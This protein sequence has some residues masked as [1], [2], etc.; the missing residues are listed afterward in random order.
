[1]LN[2]GV[3]QGCATPL[4]RSHMEPAQSVLSPRFIN[5]HA[6]A[7]VTWAVERLAGEQMCGLVFGDRGSGTRI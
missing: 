1:M 5:Q 4:S 3:A 6:C 7:F 2:L